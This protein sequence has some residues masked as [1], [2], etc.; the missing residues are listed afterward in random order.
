MD[1]IFARRAR[2]QGMLRRARS[3]ALRGPRLRVPV[4]DVEALIGLKLQALINAPS[5]R[6][7]DEADIEALFAAQHG[8]LDVR[9]LRDY[10]RLFDREPDLERLL[11]EAKSR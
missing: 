1:F 11:A 9:I 2:A 10:Y 7:R 5:R 8:S 4:V 6:A 3:R